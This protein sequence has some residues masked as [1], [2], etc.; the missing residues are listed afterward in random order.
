[1]KKPL[2][3]LLF[4]ICCNI[5]FAQEVNTKKLLEQF[6]MQPDK[7][8]QSISQL[9]TYYLANSRDSLFY[10]GNLALNKGIE[11]DDFSLMT[12]G[13]LVLSSYY[14]KVGKMEL[15]RTYLHQC[16]PYYK[17]KEDFALLADAENQMGISYFNSNNNP[18][19]I[20]YF[21]KSLETSKNLPPDNESFVGQLNLAEVYLRDELYDLAEAEALTY[22]ERVKKLNFQNATRNAYDL[23]GKINVAKNNLEVGYNYYQKSLLLT[24]KG[25]V[26]LHKA[27]SYNNIA[28]VYFENGDVD[29]A[30]EYFLK[31]LNIRKQIY[32]LIGITE[33]YYN[34]G[35]WHFF[36][37]QF[38]AALPYYFKSLQV[39]DSNNLVKEQADVLYKIALTYEALKDYKLASEFYSKY[40]AVNEKIEKSQRSEQIEM[41]RIA[42]ETQREEDRLIQSKRENIL[43]D[44]SDKQRD[45]AK[46][47]VIIF[48]VLS[49]L[50]LLLYLYTLLKRNH[51]LNTLKQ[52]TNDFSPSKSDVEKELFHKISALEDFVELN[53]KSQTLENSYFEDQIKF[54]IGMQVLKLNDGRLIFW[55]T[56]AD[57]LESYFF[58]QYMES[59]INDISDLSEFTREINKQELIDP[60]RLTYG[61]ICNQE[62]RVLVCGNNGLLI[63]NENKMA[64]MT[65][66][67]LNVKEYS[68]FVSENLKDFLIKN[69]DWDKFLKQVDMTNK[70]SS[71][72]A[73]KAIQD[74]WGDVF[75]SNNL[76]VL[77]F[78]PLS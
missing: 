15:S 20:E 3:F 11:D 73:L 34:L 25:N 10:I 57:K 39:A 18:K 29:L 46:I 52:K 8:E 50:L 31:A 74:S 14:N 9:R 35:D 58:N 36:Q 65:E 41:Q 71:N 1:M 75:R 68:V 47:I 33:S 24:L 51:H 17:R 56:N 48:S 5:S 61:F 12:L 53:Q 37:D 43:K 44:N 30:K 66:N 63:Q 23:L 4:F 67:K 49:I 6:H 60:S 27:L 54:T 22:L 7:R 62:K 2:I 69:Q 32:N 28:I 40:I 76:G 42:Y 70:M 13:K 38:K 64:F 55:E 72:M 59:I 26:K 21:V 16:I 19:A 78:Q 45:R 77:I